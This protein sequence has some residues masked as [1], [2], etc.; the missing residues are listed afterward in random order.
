MLPSQT[1]QSLKYNFAIFHGRGIGGGLMVQNDRCF[2][3]G[4]LALPSWQC[5]KAG[6][7]VKRAQMWSCN[8]STIQVAQTSHRYKVAIER[9]G[10]QQLL[11][12]RALFEQSQAAMVSLS[13][14][15]ATKLSW[16]VTPILSPFLLR[17]SL[18]PQMTH[19]AEHLTSCAWEHFTFWLTHYEGGGL[20]LHWYRFTP[21]QWLREK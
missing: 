20:H 6:S 16:L 12:E 21:Q 11:K 18:W 13:L 5:H 3:S 10:W 19:Q 9:K 2:Y 15:S 17:I 4:C 7:W 1:I 8:P 14:G